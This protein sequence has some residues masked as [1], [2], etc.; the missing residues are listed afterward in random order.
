[1]KFFPGQFKFCPLTPIRPCDFTTATHNAH[2]LL[3]SWYKLYVY[4]LGKHAYLHLFVL[5]VT[6]PSS[7]V[8]SIL[9]T[10][11]LASLP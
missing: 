8:A 6:L 5:H 1:M 10:Y 11:H 4:L 7:T 2:E 3:G 9:R